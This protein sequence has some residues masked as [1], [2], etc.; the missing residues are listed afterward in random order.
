MQ[1]LAEDVSVRATK[2]C[3]SIPTIPRFH[4]DETPFSSSP[5]SSFCVAKIPVSSSRFDR[6]VGPAPVGRAS[7]R[8]A[9]T[10]LRVEVVSPCDVS[11]RRA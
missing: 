5:F 9:G 4:S 10:V 6:F 7:A 3:V 8:H 2:N 11:G 1:S